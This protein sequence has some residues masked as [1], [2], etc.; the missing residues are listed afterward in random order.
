[1]RN[2]PL[3]SNEIVLRRLLGLGR[4]T[5]ILGWAPSSSTFEAACQAHQHARTHARRLRAVAAAGWGKEEISTVPVC[6]YYL[7]RF[8]GGVKSL[9][10]ANT[11]FFSF[12][13]FLFF[14]DKKIIAL[15]PFP[16][17]PPHPFL[18]GGWRILINHAFHFKKNAREVF[19]IFVCF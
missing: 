19:F 2:K 3:N 5:Y 14:I 6:T 10:Y 8:F 15:P 4:N 1:M 12:L 7:G 16:S 9:P 11:F 18:G 13:S 17:P